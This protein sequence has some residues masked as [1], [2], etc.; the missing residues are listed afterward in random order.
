MAVSVKENNFTGMYVK[1]EV[2]VSRMRSKSAS[3]E[4][5]LTCGRFNYT[6][7]TLFQT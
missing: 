1:R 3:G 2:S 5:A 4:S 6:A 7:K